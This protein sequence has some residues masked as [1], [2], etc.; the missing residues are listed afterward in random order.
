M[1]LVMKLHRS[2]QL[3]SS[4]TNQQ[5]DRRNRP[6]PSSVA[7]CDMDEYFYFF[8][9]AIP[10]TCAFWFLYAIIVTELANWLTARRL[11]NTKPTAREESLEKKPK[12]NTI[13]G[14]DYPEL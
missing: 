10:A 4:Q 3:V 7:A 5:K 1:Q 9:L 2:N 8:L 6:K 11:R 12:A 14:F 13:R